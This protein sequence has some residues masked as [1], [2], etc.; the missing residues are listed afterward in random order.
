MGILSA[1]RGPVDTVIA[2]IAAAA[3][4][5]AL[6]ALIALGVAAPDLE[7]HLGDHAI[8]RGGH[9]R[10]LPLVLA[11]C[12]SVLDPKL[13]LRCLRGGEFMARGIAGTLPLGEVGRGAEAR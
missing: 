10:L 11:Q 1:H 9:L 7:R 5:A 12:R 2:Q 6:A 8:R 13:G 4:H 3:S